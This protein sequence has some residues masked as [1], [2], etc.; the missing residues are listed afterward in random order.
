MAGNTKRFDQIQ[1]VT[2]I[3]TLL[4]E[5]IPLT[6][7][8]VSGTYAEP[9]GTGTD[10]NIKQ[11]AHGMFQSTF[12]YSLSDMIEVEILKDLIKTVI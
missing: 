1:D 12:D 11:Y 9:D 4:R 8:V 6:G 3:K 5:A 10:S 7:S 2:T